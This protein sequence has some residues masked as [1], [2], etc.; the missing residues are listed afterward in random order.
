[1]LAALIIVFREV[2]EAGLVVGIVSAVTRGVPR[3]LAWIGGGVVAGILGSCLVATFVGSIA[4][5]F[6]GSGHEILDASILIIAVI[7]LAWHNV[8]MAR[9]GRSLAA[10]LKAHGERVAAGRASLFALATVV[11][12]AVLREGSEIVLFLFGVAVSDGSSTVGILTGGVAG[13]LLGAAVSC[14]TYL[15][16]L[17][18]PA[19][20]LFTVTSTLIAFL[21]AGM[22]AQAIAFLEQ[23]GLLDMLSATVW[24][25]SAFLSDGSIPGRVLHTLVG[26]VDRPSQMQLLVYVATLASIFA[27]MWGLGS[28][29]RARAVRG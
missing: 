20:H 23:G 10:E 21:A 17:R 2:I 19:R 4:A 29:S 12:V 28:G 5:A 25:T 15:G 3:N 13:L 22:A 18:I 14:L 27:L 26:Y 11:A 7:M 6:S 9:H 16:M 24:N 8:W 1:M